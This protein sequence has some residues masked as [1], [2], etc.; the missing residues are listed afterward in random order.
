MDVDMGF[1]EGLVMT[2]K[3]F[4][5]FAGL[6][7]SHYSHGRIEDPI[8]SGGIPVGFNLLSGGRPTILLMVLNSALVPGVKPTVLGAAEVF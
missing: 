1:L 2:F 5:Y 3:A 7:C 6:S 8:S 4:E